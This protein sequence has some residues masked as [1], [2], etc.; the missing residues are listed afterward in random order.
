[1]EE[2]LTAPYEAL[3][4]E[5]PPA[6]PAG[7]R[8]PVE[9]DVR[10]P[11]PPPA[12]APD[13]RRPAPLLAR[14]SGYSDVLAG[15]GPDGP[16]SDGEAAT[17]EPLLSRVSVDTGTGDDWS[18]LEAPPDPAGLHGEVPAES[19]SAGTRVPSDG[20]AATNTTHQ[21]TCRHCGVVFAVNE[22]L[23]YLNHVEECPARRRRRRGAG[24]CPG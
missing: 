23:V 22:H 13:R 15:G 18:Q 16:A 6:P 20:Y 9:S 10:R 12:P 4:T 11:L 8:P 21:V 3:R 2:V 14:D 24:P 7:R 17:A 1:M 19:S 5:P